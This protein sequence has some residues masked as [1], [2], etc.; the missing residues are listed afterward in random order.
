MHNIFYLNLIC[1][2]FQEGEEDKSSSFPTESRL[3]DE[4]GKEREENKFSSCPFAM[5][6]EREELFDFAKAREIEVFTHP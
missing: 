4:G 3:R 6:R 2:N 5:T 1:L